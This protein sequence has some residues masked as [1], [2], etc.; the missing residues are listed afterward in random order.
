MWKH[1]LREEQVKNLAVR[2][3]FQT[4]ANFLITLFGDGLTNYHNLMLCKVDL[5]ACTLI[6]VRWSTERT[7]SIM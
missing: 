7:E 1:S 5:I 6:C 2:D 3:T 4:L